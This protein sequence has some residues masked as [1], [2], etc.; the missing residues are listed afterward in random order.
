M[1]GHRLACA[2]IL[3]LASVSCGDMARDGQASS[4]LVI[5]ALQA[6]PGAEPAAMGGTLNSDVTPIFNDVGEVEFAL[7]M[8]DPLTGPSPA[9]FITIDRYH[10]R[11]FRTDGHNIEGVDVPYAFD[12]AITGTVSDAASFGFTIVRHQAKAEAPL[13]ALGHE[14]RDPVH[15]RRSDLLRA[16]PDGPCGQRDGQNRHQL[17]GLRRS[18]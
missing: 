6:A 18:L 11:Y 1:Q 17:R 13:S 7:S 9:N 5:T 8:K 4:Y 12:S 15:H 10:V 3:V 2:V 16:R 14:F